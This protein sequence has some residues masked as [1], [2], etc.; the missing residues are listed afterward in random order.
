MAAVVEI[1]WHYPIGMC[2]CPKENSEIYK[3]V[4]QFY[5]R[6]VQKIPF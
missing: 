2:I 5:Q 4:Q 3:S 1:N 6:R